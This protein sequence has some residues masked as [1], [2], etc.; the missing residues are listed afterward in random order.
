MQKILID[1]FGLVGFAALGTGLYLKYGMAD[2]SLACGAL[3]MAISAI[4]GFRRHK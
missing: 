2:T 4:A 3:M 1:A